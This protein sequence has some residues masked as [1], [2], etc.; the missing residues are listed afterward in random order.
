[1]KI[2]KTIKVN[3]LSIS[4]GVEAV[5]W[6]DCVWCDGRDD[7]KHVWFK[8]W[9]YRLLC[10]RCI[11]LWSPQHWI[12]CSWTQSIQGQDLLR[13][14]WWCKYEDVVKILGSQHCQ[15]CLINIFTILPIWQPSLTCVVKTRLN[16]SENQIFLSEVMTHQLDWP[17]DYVLLNW[18]YD[19]HLTQLSK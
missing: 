18:L 13:W 8:L 10:P 6:S 12:R 2:I 14:W 3:F 16:I 9:S 5:L 11:L 17:L 7:R 15:P 4:S 1:M 19:H